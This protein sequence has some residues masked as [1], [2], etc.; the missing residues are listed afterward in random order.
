MTNQLNYKIPKVKK[1]MGPTRCMNK[2][3]GTM[4]Q[5][6]EMTRLSLAQTVEVKKNQKNR[7]N[8]ICT[9]DIFPWAELVKYLLD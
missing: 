1:I 9:K 4:I 2:V 5:C 6:Y 8:N 7:E 3:L